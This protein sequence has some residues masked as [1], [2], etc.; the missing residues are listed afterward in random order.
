MDSHGP[1]AHLVQF[2]ENDVFLIG[3]LADFIGAALSGGDKG[4]VIAT[5][6]HRDMLEQARVW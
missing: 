2:Y 4:I 6:D 1:H 3:G 5:R